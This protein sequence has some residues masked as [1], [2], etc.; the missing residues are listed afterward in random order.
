MADNRPIGVFDSGLGGLT[1]VKELVKLLPNENI[2]YFG[3][4]G[5][6]PYGTRSPQT[7]E[8]YAL[9]DERFLLSKGVK[10]IIAACGTVSAV[11]AHTGQSLPVPFVEVVSHAAEAAVKATRNGR[12]GVLATTA[13]I[14]SGT[15]TSKILKLMPQSQ[16]ISNDCPLFVSLVEAGWIDRN[17]CVTVETAKRYL[18]PMIDA[19]VDTLILG[20][21]HFPVLSDIIKDIM[22]NSTELVNASRVTA[23]AAAEYLKNHDMLSDNNGKGIYKYYV[24][25]RTESFYKTASY[26]LGNPLDGELVHVDIDKY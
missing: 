1:V 23:V 10:L 11:A 4:T 7:I 16:I 17:D 21:T 18:Q 14:A 6:V 22:G 19:K 3:D 12:I 13:A 8:K 15:Y 25:D 5:R 26:L 2:V 20:C 9:Q 24:S